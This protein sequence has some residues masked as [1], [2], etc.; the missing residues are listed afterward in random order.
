MLRRAHTALL[1]LYRVLPRK[2]R[3][4]IL[5]AV[6]PSFTVGALCVV[7]RTD[8]RILLVR[9]SYRRRW[10]LPGGLVKRHEEIDA[11]ARREA[12]EE[13]G[14]EIELVGEPSVVVASRSRRVDVIYRAEVVDGL[15]PDEARPVSPEIV[16]VRWVS[17]DELPALQHEAAGGLVALARR[18]DAG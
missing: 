8:G 3:R 14:I 6:A 2:V 4:S 5:H 16:E 10:G 12:R 18:L 7:E 9:H 15:D 13:V 17:P 1:R 11:A